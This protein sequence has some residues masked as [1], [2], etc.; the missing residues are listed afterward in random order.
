MHAPLGF[1]KMV[2]GYS[3][4]YIRLLLF[5]IVIINISTF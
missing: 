4:A 3:L 2:I 1:R 5:L